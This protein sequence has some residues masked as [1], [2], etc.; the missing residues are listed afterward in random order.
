MHLIDLSSENSQDKIS[1]ELIVKLMTVIISIRISLQFDVTLYDV[2]LYMYV[3][4]LK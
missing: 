4:V 2:T 3:C 1:C